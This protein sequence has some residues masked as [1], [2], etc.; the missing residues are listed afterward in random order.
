MTTQLV[1]LFDE[2]TGLHAGTYEAQEDP[3]EP[4]KFIAPIHSTPDQPPD[5]ALGEHP[6]WGGDKGW[7]SVRVAPSESPGKLPK[8]LSFED[9]RVQKQSELSGACSEA[10]LAGFQHS[11]LGSSHL[12]PSG[13]TDQLNMASLIGAES[14]ELPCQSVDDKTWDYRLHTAAQ[15]QAVLRHITSSILANRK[16]HS[17]LQLAVN[18][19]DP[20]DVD[21]V[22]KLDAI[23][24]W[25][26]AE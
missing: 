11:A 9:L 19:I 20:E 25:E 10:C 6:K 17:V 7:K 22:A 3:L 21:A 26:K 15:F 14:V 12:Y 5:C 13:F 18:D 1:H 2:A 23:V 8:E 4:G 24:W 16:K